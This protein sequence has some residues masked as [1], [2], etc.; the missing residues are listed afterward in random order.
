MPGFNLTQG[1][2]ASLTIAILLL[3]TAGYLFGKKDRSPSAW[4][5]TALLFVCFCWQFIF[6]LNK[7][8]P[9]YWDLFFGTGEYIIQI[10]M[11][12]FLIQFAYR[13]PFS[14]PSQI[15]ESRL[16]LFISS[17]LTLSYG[18]FNAYATTRFYQTLSWK[19]FNLPIIQIGLFQLFP[20][21]LI[22]ATVW[23]IIVFLRKIP[24]LSETPKGT[25]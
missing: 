10:L 23:T 5:L 18:G 3:V 2:V 8:T 25:R 20:I 24:H 21:L 14:V 1:S 4:Y 17:F 16:V 11:M 13:F 15:K 19:Q 7:S 22:I 12:T 9:F 6:F